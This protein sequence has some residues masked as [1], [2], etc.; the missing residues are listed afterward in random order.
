MSDF[1]KSIIKG[2]FWSVFGQMASL[3]IILITNIWLARLLSPKEFGQIGVI[4]FFITLGSVFTESGLGGALVRKKEATKTDYSTVFVSNLILSVLS[5]I[6]IFFSAQFIASY[7]DDNL[8]E[9]LLIVS[10]LVL[11]INAF[12]LTQNAKL[13][14]EMRFKP[15]AIY[16]FIAVL[17]S[18]IIGVYCAYSGMG[19]WSLVLIQLLTSSLNTLFLW[20]FEGFFMKFYFSKASFKELYAF[21]VNTTV[22]SLLNTG[23]DNIYQVILARYFSLSQ[24]GYFYQ[25]KKLQDVPG[26]VI[27]MVTHSVIFSSL[28]KLQDNKVAF[29]KA[30]NKITL[31]FLVLL[32]FISIFIYLYAEPIVLL[33]Y[34]EDWLGMVFYLQLLTIA[35]FFFIQENMNRV[36]FKVFNK[37]RQILYLEYFK[38]SLQLVSILIGVYYLDLEIL[39][40]GFVIT[41]IIGYLINYY[42]S[43]KIIKDVDNIRE[44]L[45]IFKICLLSIIIIIIISLI[46]DIF[47]FTRY[48]IFVTIPL[49][50][51][52]YIFGL[53]K[54]KIFEFFK[55]SALFISFYRNHFK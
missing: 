9:N 36:I 4:M 54:L 10:S 3:I 25:A 8:L 23:F 19:I 53:L 46:I 49:F 26:G 42:Y 55:E 15:R 38:K 28:T 50:C 30:Y 11:I 37:T 21:G 43:R 32:G 6:I 2:A 39:I 1:K 40:I 24:T 14:S 48:S 5:F 45:I 16:R 34:G 7:Y 29:A 13:I 35:S 52:L 17:V 12:Q 31:Y 47:S 44:L 41:N 18:S 33:L 20:L 22:A 51:G 27:S